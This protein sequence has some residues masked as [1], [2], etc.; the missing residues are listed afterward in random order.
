M[1]IPTLN[2]IIKLQIF[3]LWLILY[4]SLDRK[5]MSIIKVTSKNLPH[6]RFSDEFIILV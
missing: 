1:I 3:T 2:F 6:G 4:E 5:P